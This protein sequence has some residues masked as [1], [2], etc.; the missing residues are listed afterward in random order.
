MRNMRII[1]WLSVGIAALLGVNILLTFNDSQ[2]TAIVQRTSLLPFPDDAV[3]LIEI[4][5]GGVVESVLTHTG[6]WRLVEPFAGSVD[7]A[8]VL[9]LLDALAYAPLDDSLGDQELLRLGRTRADFGLESPRL[10]VR[11]RAGASEAAISFGSPTPSASGVYAAIDDVRAVFVVP[12]NTFAAVDVPASGFRRRT[13][14]TSGEESVAS[15]DVKRGAGEF[16]RFRREGDGWLMV[17]PTEGPASLTKIKK[18]LSD[19]MSASAV[20]FVWP[21]GGSNEVAEAS[22]ALLAGYGL[23][24]ESAVTLTLK[25]T[26]GSDR[27]ISFGSDAGEGRVYALVHN[28]AAVVTVDA[29]LKDLV[30]PGNSALADTRLFP[31]ETSQVSSISI[32]DGGVACMLAKNEDGTWRMDSPISAAA[33]ST[34]VDSLLSAVL[35][36]RGG[37]TDENG[38]EV[39]ISADERKV[40]VSRAALGPGFRLENL[41]SLEILKIDP[42]SVRRLSVTG[43]GTNGT[44]SVVYDRDRRAWS[45]EVSSVK[46]T[47]SENGVARVLGVVNPLEAGRI[48]KLKVSADDLGGY[49]LEKPRLT[50]A[51]DLER[52]DAIRRNILVGDATDGGCFATVGASDAVFVLPESAVYDLS[53]DI[54]E[55]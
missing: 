37:D 2:D 51:I 42:A 50:V 16:M 46:G 26:D 4:S 11:I 35:A 45:V 6:S 5:R 31:Y 47:V 3:S 9:K 18:L 48:V 20:D 43:S 39:S 13:L 14:F 38:V 27:R 7:E 53:A 1:V 29:A 36:L 19:V 33:S 34:A 17:Q 24:V 22:D 25:G 55:E 23:G 28:G 41:R 32:A 54:V 15:F 21:V 10:A 30:S 40:R 49:G 52:E 44:E 12:S 8:V